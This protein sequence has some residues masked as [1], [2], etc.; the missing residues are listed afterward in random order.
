MK[1]LRLEYLESNQKK[2]QQQKDFLEKQVAKDIRE[3]SQQMLKTK[4]EIKK[5]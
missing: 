2:M 3:M 5:D 4:V 1:E